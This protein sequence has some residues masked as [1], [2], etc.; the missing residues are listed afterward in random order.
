MYACIY[1]KIHAAQ[2]HRDSVIVTALRRHVR[3]ALNMT[4][5][6]IFI[7]CV[8]MKHTRKQVANALTTVS[9]GDK[10]KPMMHMT[11]L[12]IYI[13]CAYVH[14]YIYIYIYI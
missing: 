4:A 3:S 10:H 13:Y 12:H 5:L 1:L 9:G 14:I 7:W 2:A 8:C 11:A 6:D